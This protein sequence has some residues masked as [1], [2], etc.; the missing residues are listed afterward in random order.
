MDKKRATPL[1]LYHGQ[2]D[3]TIPVELSTMTYNVFEELKFNY[4]FQTEPDLAHSLSMQ[5]IK[6]VSGFFAKLMQ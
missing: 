5:E 2:D 3:P 6:E 4:T 1:F